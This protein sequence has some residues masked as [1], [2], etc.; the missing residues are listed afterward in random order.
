MYNMGLPFNSSGDDFGIT[1]EGK[2]ENGYL[3]SSRGQKK[4]LDQ[5]YRFVLPE[6]VFAVEG[7][8]TDQVGEPVSE[9][10]IRLVGN[11]GTNQKLQVRKDG[12]YRITLSKDV[13]YVMLATARGYLNMKQDLQ[14]MELDDSRTYTQDFQLTMISKPVTMDNIFYEFG[15][16]DLTPESE[17]GMQSLVKLLTD[18]PNITIE[19]S[20]HTDM[21]GD[22][23]FNLRLSEKRAQSC[24]KYLIDH[25]IE[26]ERLTPVGY[27][28]QRPVVADKAMSKRYRF[29]PL[30]QELTP[31]FILTLNEKQQEICNQINRRTEFR[32]LKTTY[33][34]Y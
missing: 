20:A 16:W 19:L 33:K 26:A 2:T 4:G 18:N 22:S 31:E 32:V 3:S 1:F 23:V 10:T 25:G 24:V 21:V 27:G 34:M 29:I 5:I 15:K 12:T 28:K 17:T 13:R 6:M 11:D 7:T 8:V 9:A 30:G 14:T